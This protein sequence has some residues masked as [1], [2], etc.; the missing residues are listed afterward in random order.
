LNPGSTTDVYPGISAVALDGSIGENLLCAEPV[1]S[2]WK[3]NDQVRKPA[4]VNAGAKKTGPPLPSERQG[5][6]V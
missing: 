2:R 3:P 4:I 5:G 6:P 1:T